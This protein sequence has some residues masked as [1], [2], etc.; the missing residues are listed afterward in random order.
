MSRLDAI[1][2]RADSERPQALQELKAGQKRGHW[3]WWIFPT[4]AVRGGD[5]N[6]LRQINGGADFQSAHEAAAYIAHPGLRPGLLDAFEA[7]DAAF[8]AASDRAAPCVAWLHTHL[9]L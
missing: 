9:N 4:L 1:A 3:V 2:V 6:S 8:T 7:A 5:A